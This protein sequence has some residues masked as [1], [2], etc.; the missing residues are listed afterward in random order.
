METPLTLFHK[1]PLSGGSDTISWAV[2]LDYLQGKRWPVSGP[3]PFLLKSQPSA[4]A[5]IQGSSNLP[6]PPGVPTLLPVSIE[7]WWALLGAS[8]MLSSQGFRSPPFLPRRRDSGAWGGRGSHCAPHSYSAVQ[9]SGVFDTG[10]SVVCVHTQKEKPEITISIKPC[11]NINFAEESHE[12]KPRPRGFLEQSRY[13][14]V[15]RKFF[16]STNVC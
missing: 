4:S 14:H 10:S 11:L 13:T 9:S 6:G 5:R 16:H 1:H 7:G 12:C 3:E 2:S 15:S 8:G